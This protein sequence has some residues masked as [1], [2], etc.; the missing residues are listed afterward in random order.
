MTAK[1]V[2]RLCRLVQ[3]LGAGPKTRSFLTRKLRVDARGF[4]RDYQQLRK[5][6][7]PVQMSAGRYAL[8][9]T[10]TDA[11]ARLPFPNPCLSVQ[12]VLQLA[13]GRTSVHQKLRQQIQ[14]LLGKPPKR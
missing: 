7:V 9:E 2:A 1:R 13:R 3:L 10:V 8:L 5:C 12:E 11:L 14:N 6:G 4:F